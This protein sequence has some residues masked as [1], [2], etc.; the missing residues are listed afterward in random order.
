MSDQLKVW[1]CAVEKILPLAFL[2]EQHIN[3]EK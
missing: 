2:C 3:V 1:Y